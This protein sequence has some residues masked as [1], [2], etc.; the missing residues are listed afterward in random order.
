[1]TSEESLQDQPRQ[2]AGFPGVP[3]TLPL[4]AVR[5]EHLLNHVPEALIDDRRV[6]SWVALALVND[7][8]PI[9]PVLQHQ[10]QRPAGHLTCPPP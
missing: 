3:A 10:I 9:D 4:D 6:L 7:L 1:M 5:G 8:T 2:Q